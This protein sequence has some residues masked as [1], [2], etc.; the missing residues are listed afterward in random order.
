[1]FDFRPRNQK[2]TR[3]CCTM[4]HDFFFLL[5]KL[6]TKGFLFLFPCFL[7]FLVARVSAPT[8][9]SSRTLELI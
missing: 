7:R 6:N 9:T 3:E 2:P 5:N 4:I 1:M 8:A